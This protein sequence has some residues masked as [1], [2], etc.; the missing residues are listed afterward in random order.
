MPAKPLIRA[1]LIVSIWITVTGIGA[2]STLAGSSQIEE[3]IAFAIQFALASSI[4]GATTLIV[5]GK[6]RLGWEVLS[7]TAAFSFLLGILSYAVFW[8]GAIPLRAI[9]RLG[10]YNVF[11]MRHLLWETLLMIVRFPSILGIG[12]GISVGL[13]AGI[14]MRLKR[15]ALAGALGLALLLAFGASFDFLSATISNLVIQYRLYG[16]YWKVSSVNADEMAS[17]IGAA[18]GSVIGATVACMALRM[19][20]PAEAIRHIECV[21]PLAE[22]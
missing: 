13:V 16:G 21:E 6:K 11:Y 3:V 18:T 15:P 10:Y 17:A 8:P 22:R 1:I 2:G 20:R 9:F 7:S 14:I 19:A 12:G 4:A 5:S